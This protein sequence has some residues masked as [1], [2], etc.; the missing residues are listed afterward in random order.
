MDGDAVF[1]CCVASVHSLGRLC[2]VAEVG[3]MMDTRIIAIRNG[4]DWGD[5]SCDHLVVPLD[6]DLEAAAVDWNQWYKEQYCVAL[7]D[8]KAKK[9]KF[10]NFTDWLVEH[11]GAC[12][13]DD[14]EL[15]EIEAP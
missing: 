3:E 1:A 7:K 10:L 2:P 11:H 12:L 8:P 9:M 15:L 14:M 4:C 13:P 6:V 5:A